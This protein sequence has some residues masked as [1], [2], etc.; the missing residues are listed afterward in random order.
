MNVE[1]F[2]IALITIILLFNDLLFISHNG[3]HGFNGFRLRGAF[4]LNTNPTNRTNRI[5]NPINPLNPLFSI[6]SS[7]K[8]PSTEQEAAA[9]K[10]C[11]EIETDVRGLVVTYI[12]HRHAVA[13]DRVREESV[14]A[15]AR[16]NRRYVYAQAAAVS[17]A[18][19]DIFAPVAEDVSAEAR[20][21]F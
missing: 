13:I 21:G 16:G 18:D 9:F 6:D 4:F 8:L 20:V 3:L 7:L 12:L 17:R 10:F 5:N 1:D 2:T 14:E 11:A 15:V 19:N